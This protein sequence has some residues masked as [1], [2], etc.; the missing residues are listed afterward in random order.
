[1]KKR[2]L[3]FAALFFMLAQM[4]LAQTVEVSGKVTD[5]NGDPIVGVSVSQKNSSIGTTTGP[6]GMF[7][8]Q[9]DKGS[10]LVFTSIGYGRREIPSSNASSVVLSISSEAISE[11]VVT[12]FGIKREK[13]ALGY[14]VAT[15]DAKLLEQ[16]PESDVVRLLNGKAPGVDI[17]NTSGI[18][19]SGT[20]IIIRGVSTIT[21]SST[22]LFVVDGV[23]F[24]ASTNAQAS[25]VYGN[26]TS[27]RFLDLDPN[28]IES[29]SVLKG[30]SATVLYGEFGRNGVVLVTTKGGA[31]RRTKSKAEVTVTQSMFANRVSNLPDYQDTY[32]GGFDQSVGLVFFSNWGAAFRNPPQKVAHPYDRA[33]LHVA[34]PEYNQIPG[35]GNDT[36]Y[37]Y[38][39]Y[40]SVERFFRTG[41]LS[42]TSVGVQSGGPNGSFSA[43]Y[44]Y[45]Y[46]K[47]F[48]PG[49]TLTK[50]NFSVGGNAKLTN[51]LDV[52]G[53]FNYVITDFKTPPTATSFGSNPSVSSVFGNLI[54]TPRAV[55]LMGGPEDGNN[56]LP[57]ENPL[58]KSSVYFRGNNDIQNPRWTVANSFAGQKINRVF[59]HL[60]FG[61]QLLKSLNLTYRVGFD[62][63]TDFNFLSQ[64]KGGTVGADLIY[65]RGIHRTVTGQNN[66]WDHAFLL[67][68]A[69][70]LSSS[71]RLNVDAGLNS[72]ERRYEQTGQRST[73]QLVY[74][75]FDHD[76]FIVHDN[77]DE[78]GGQI[79]FKVESFSLGAF[80]QATIAYNEFLYMTLGGRNSWTS[81]LERDNRT[82][83]YPS[84]SSSFIPT[85]AFESLRNS[86]MVN[87]LKIRAGYATSANFGR[88]YTTRPI[89][90]INTNVFE[91]RVGTVIN[92]NSISNRLP[93]P[94]L[95]PEL[96]G[97]IEL[98]IE[99]KFINNLINLDLTFYRRL[100]E[101]Q[102]L[103]R[104][105]DPSTGFTVQSINAGN[106]RNK[107]IELGLG[108]TAIRSKNWR[109]QLDGNFTLNRSLV[110][111]LPDDIKQIVVDGFSDEGLFAINGQ[112]LGVIQASYVVKVDPKNG[113]PTGDPLKGSRL[114]AP[115]GDYVASS[116]IGVIGNPIP[117]FKLAGISTLS[118]KGFSF[119]MQWDWTQGGDMLAYTPGTLI[120][121][122]LTR[123]T[124]FDRLLP[125]ILP[126]VQADGTPNTVQ[127]S[128][129]Q[130]YFNNYSGFF[131]LQDLITY[132]A[133]VIRLR[134]ASLA[135]SVPAKALKKTPFG[136]LSLTISGQNLWYNA[137]NFPKHT[138]F[139]PEVT[140]LGVS[141]VR[142]LE[143]L[144]GP[145]SR[146]LGASLRVT[147]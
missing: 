106:V 12:S 78:E 102:I 103:D 52:G 13:K 96:I 3:L 101:D 121:R 104:S 69:K 80:A 68:W 45:T 21:G 59:G 128:A 93:N 50:N 33:A 26:T 25:F 141:N 16:R 126:G 67:D 82:L 143:Y 129:S 9:V 92:S 116:Q 8:I 49:N 91:D 72:Q 120:G 7:K 135:Y 138:N 29:I 60:R 20:N 109:W 85:T 43:N 10:T 81:N 54:Y 5:E 117:D 57:W 18:S 122:G 145:T 30:V 63:Y 1:M 94:D 39:P 75:L 90:N 56:Y 136:S 99:G 36:I 76:N 79:D 139:D 24:D 66:I 142:G 22:P 61:Y 31:G 83:F 89:L 87:Y 105:L 28:N 144:A 11:V 74:G 132:D 125:L 53:V 64:H 88:P 23:P 84:I 134:E 124:D 95:K 131:S 19:G 140:S 137:P 147:F 123:D 114:V 27:S 115:G 118:Y 34:F 46:D 65:R 146:R 17:M 127:I 111:K 71:W 100:S 40:N 41:L 73:Q 130:A 47:G 48:T 77:F 98:G 51:K 119:R 112:P 32:G 15:V 110:S 35:A 42:T 38:K 97:E 107:G 44:S 113:Q 108:V 70:N 58:D 133:T 62:N 6:D 86:K 14:A 4:V 55:N 2:L 37:E